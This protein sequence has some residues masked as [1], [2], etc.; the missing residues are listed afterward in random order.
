MSVTLALH[1]PAQ[2]TN[3]HERQGVRYRIEFQAGS[4][5]SEV[6]ATIADQAIAALDVAWP[7]FRKFLGARDGA[8]STI[9][10]YHDA[11]EFD[12]AL[13]KNPLPFPVPAFA[14]VDG[15]GHALLTPRLPRRA[16]A[17]VGLPP[18][19]RENMLRVAAELAV[20]PVIASSGAAADDGLVHW[21][22]T[23]GA[24]E[25]ATNARHQPGVDGPHDARRDLARSPAS[26]RVT[27][28]ELRQ[29]RVVPTDAADFRLLQA[30]MAFAAQQFG[31]MNK[32]WVRRILARQRPVDAAPST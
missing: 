22:L 27:I 25:S 6:A 14:T 7:S 17:A 19:T 1:C 31:A 15:R 18:Q 16:L 21:L 24:L 3:L 28:H 2:Q 32:G 4:L 12:A 30:Q 29:L 10:L 11:K 13:P 23:M 5:D 26:K 9:V 20:Q 8:V